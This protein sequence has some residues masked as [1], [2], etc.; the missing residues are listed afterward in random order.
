MTLTT[1]WRLR[2]QTRARQF[3][4]WLRGQRCRGRG[5]QYEVL[6][7]VGSGLRCTRCGRTTYGWTNRTTTVA[8]VSITEVRM[9]ARRAVTAFKAHQNGGM[10]P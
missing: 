1:H 6:Q 3:R 8:P 9:R 7:P 2:L 5:H 10:Q 4:S